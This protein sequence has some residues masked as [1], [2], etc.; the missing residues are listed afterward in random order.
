MPFSHD[1]SAQFDDDNL[2]GRAGLVPVMALADS[3]ELLNLAREGVT[4][5]GSSGSNVGV[6]GPSLVA[7]MIAGADSISDMDL[8]R[9]GG[10]GQALTARRA[11]TTL[12]T[13]LRGYMFGHVR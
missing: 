4:V 2:S 8:L 6:K 13:H 3:A 11:P 1:F 12:A 7:G 5:S 9:L 10:F